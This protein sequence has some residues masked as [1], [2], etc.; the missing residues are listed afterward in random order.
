[1][2]EITQARYGLAAADSATH[3]YI[4]GGLT[5]VS[6]YGAAAFQGTIEKFPFS[7]DTNAT[8]VGELIGTGADGAG[9][10]AIEAGFF[11]KAVNDGN[12]YGENIQKVPF[13][14]D[15]SSVDVGELQNQVRDISA[16][17]I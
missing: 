7:S 3:G 16:S 14:S 17:Q 4:S 9:A 8:D 12:G 2:G 1:V 15:T 11:G 6:P 5:G 13:S 10:S